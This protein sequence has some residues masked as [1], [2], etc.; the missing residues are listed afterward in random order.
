MQ[1]VCVPPDRAAQAWPLAQPMI[2]AAMRRGGV[3]AVDPVCDDVLAGRAL[4]WL[5][6]DGQE[7][8]A[9]A[10][11]EIGTVNG[12]KLCTIVGCGGHGRAN[13]LHLIEGLES[14]A[15]AEGCEATRIIGRKGWSRL[16][17]EYRQKAVILE[18]A[19]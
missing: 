13:W 11:T 19:L 12:R 18:R 1:L 16:L 10:V 15:R 8:A 2:V 4:L 17:P 9:A 3:S 7:I 6:W 14:F 5:A